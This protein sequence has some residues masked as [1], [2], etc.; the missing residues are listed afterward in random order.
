[1]K[2]LKARRNII[3]VFR[4]EG[5]ENWSRY[6]VVKTANGNRIIHIGGAKLNHGIIQLLLGQAA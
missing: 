2:I 4:G 1:M 6:R 3:D 5:W